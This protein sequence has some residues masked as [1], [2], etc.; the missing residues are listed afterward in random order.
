MNVVVQ[1]IQEFSRL[2]QTS[3]DPLWC[4]LRF[5]LSEKGLNP[6]ALLVADFFPDDCQFE[7][8]LVVAQDHSVF[9]FGF[10]YLHKTVEEGAFSEWEE[11]TDHFRE[12][13]YDEQISAALQMLS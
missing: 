12:T 5:L 13:P 6:Q 4:R 11:L 10:D 8:G 3:T 9:Q 1:R 2:L 7:F